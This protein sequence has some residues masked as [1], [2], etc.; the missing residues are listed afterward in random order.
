MLKKL[1]EN[2]KLVIA[3]IAIVII[4]LVAL[5]VRCG[6]DEPAG[7]DSSPD[8]ETKQEEA[9]DGDGLEIIEDD[10]NSENSVDTSEYWEDEIESGSDADRS[11]TKKDDTT[12]DKA[13][14]SKMED[15]KAE[16]GMTEGSESTG[17]GTEG[18]ESEGGVSGEETLEDEKSWGDI[19]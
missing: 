3:I 18:T 9:Y 8:K 10:G 17:D 1:L 13:T 11:D 5:L 16:N 14:D 7:T 19:Y 4:V 6:T 15:N 2:K 12:S